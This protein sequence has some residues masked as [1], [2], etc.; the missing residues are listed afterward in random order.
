MNMPA[1]MMSKRPAF[2]PG[3]KRA[4]LGQH[5]VDLGDADLRQDGLRHFR[6]FAGEL[7]V[8]RGVAKRRFVRETDADEA[9]RF[10]ALERGLRERRRTSRE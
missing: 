1:A 4:E 10:G 2:R 7:A 6:R 9:V 5:A 3:I 8:G